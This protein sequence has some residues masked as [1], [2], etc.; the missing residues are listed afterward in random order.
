MIGTVWVQVHA[1]PKA[2]ADQIQYMVDWIAAKYP[3][4]ESG[5][6]YCLTRKD[7]EQVATELAQHGLACGCYH[8]DMDPVRRESVHM[9]WSSG[10]TLL[11]CTIQPRVGNCSRKEKS[12]LLG[13]M[14]VIHV[15]RISSGLPFLQQQAEV[16]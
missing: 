8:A 4:G 16:T 10:A 13:I 3:N 14:M 1:K 5:I 15:P 2:A 11:F 9:Q 7:T 6:V 12:V